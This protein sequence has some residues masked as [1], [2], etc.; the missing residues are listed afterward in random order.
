MTLGNDNILYEIESMDISNKAKRRRAIYLLFEFYGGVMTEVGEVHLGMHGVSE[1]L[2]KQQW[3]R[4][5]TR[6]ESM[7]DFSV[8]EKYA[9]LL[10]R[11]HDQRNKVNHNFMYNPPKTEI[12]TLIER[13]DGWRNWIQEEVKR[14]EELKEKIDPRKE[15]VNMA[16]DSL[17]YVINGDIDATDGLQGK[18]RALELLNE[19]DELTNSTDAITLELVNILKEANN[20]RA[21]ADNLKSFSESDSL[22]S[23]AKKQ[24]KEILSEHGP[25]TVTEVATQVGLSNSYVRYVLRELESKD[26]VSKDKLNKVIGVIF[27]GELE[28]L[29]SDKTQLLH[30]MRKHAPSQ[31]E[32]TEDLS[33][34]ELQNKLQ[35]L[36]DATTIIGSTWKY[37]VE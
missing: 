13:T 2:P 8:P 14:Y 26:E 23:I 3:N 15:I 31:Y 4:I 17:L 22:S 37:D 10:H 12:E 6:L 33:E 29:T 5:S 18:M 28:V 24:L 1:E 36:A 27:D 20:L 30:I 16:Q 21:A 25:M 32:E 34:R 19:L 11:L 7:S 35:K 9:G